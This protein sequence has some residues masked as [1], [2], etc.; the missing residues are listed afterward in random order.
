M[1]TLRRIYHVLVDEFQDN[2]LAQGEIVKLMSEH[3]KSTC[4]VVTKTRLSSD[5]GGECSES[6]DFLEA[7]ENTSNLTRIDLDTCYRHSQNI[8][9]L[10]FF[11]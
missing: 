8:I 11:D 2:N 3:L 7:F 4:V 5:L 9:D 6:E 1:Q 10:V